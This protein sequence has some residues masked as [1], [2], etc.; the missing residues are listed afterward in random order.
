M[1][2]GWFLLFLL[3]AALYAVHAVIGLVRLYRPGRWGTLRRWWALAAAMLAHTAFLVARGFET[4]TLPVE[5]RLDS[6]ALFLWVTAVVFLAAGRPYRLE[7]VA[8]LFWVLFAAGAMAAL[9]LA[10]RE[11][12]PRAA[13]AR[14]WLVLHLVPVYVGY[15]GFAA[16]A[17]AGA[18]YLVQERLLRRKAV[19]PLWRKLPSLETLE[20][21]DRLALAL[22]F[23]MLTLGLAV[24]VFWAERNVGLLGRAWYADPKVVGGIVVW[25]FYAA[26]LHVRLFARLRGRRAA[27]LTIAGFILTLASFATVHLYGSARGPAEAGAPRPADIR[28]GT[29]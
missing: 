26:V 10:S 12:A 16:A 9:A 15:A 20:R 29:R 1:A 18:T 13:L 7:G 25:L 27:L 28:A 24:G 4:G 17:G 21:V 14:F 8:P 22:G 5:S 2:G 11:P 3:A 19:G 6:L 23:P